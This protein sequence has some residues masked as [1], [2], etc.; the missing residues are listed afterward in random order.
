[1]TKFQKI[2]KSYDLRKNDFP[3]YRVATWF[4]KKYQEKIL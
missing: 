2:N 1:M 3:S 4:F